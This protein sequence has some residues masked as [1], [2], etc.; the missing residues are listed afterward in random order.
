MTLEDYYPKWLGQSVI[1]DDLPWNFAEC[2]TFQEFSET[3]TLHDSIWV[4][5]YQNVAYDDSVTL[6]IRWDAVWLP[7]EV[8]AS[9]SFVADWPLLF[10]KIEN[11]HQIST[12]GYRDVGG[13]QRGI[14]KAEIE[15]VDGKQLL[16]ISDHY[17]GNVEI[18]FSGKL[19]F[20]ALN[21]N[22]E[23]LKI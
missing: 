9:T 7:D 18:I 11:V 16:V 10:I 19:S 17:G 20:L 1:E 8:A 5:I 12:S 21:R 23:P 13:I 22:K 14:G 2:L 6:V 4:T 3:Y 15:G